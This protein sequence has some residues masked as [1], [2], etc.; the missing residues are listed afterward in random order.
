M[1]RE[2][3]PS[4]FDELFGTRRSQQGVD[5]GLTLMLDAHTDQLAPSSIHDDFQGFLAL[6]HNKQAHTRRRG[7]KS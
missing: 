2:K 1:R 7:I 5:K 6:I 4:I 3:F